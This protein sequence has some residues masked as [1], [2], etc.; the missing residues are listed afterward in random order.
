MRGHAAIA[1]IL[2]SI[3]ILAGISLGRRHETPRPMVHVI[4]TK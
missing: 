3:V 2:L 1:M 4:G